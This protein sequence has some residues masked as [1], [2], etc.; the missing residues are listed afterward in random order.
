M[1]ERQAEHFFS[2]SLIYHRKRQYVT[3]DVVDGGSKKKQ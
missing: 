2:K 3:V 1:A